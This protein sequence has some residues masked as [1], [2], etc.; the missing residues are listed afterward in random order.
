[1]GGWYRQGVDVNQEVMAVSE[2]IKAGK[3]RVEQR[4]K[5]QAKASKKNPK[6]LDPRTITEAD[7][8]EML[9][10]AIYG[11]YDDG[12][13]LPLRRNTPEFFIGVVKEHSKGTYFIEDYPIAA[14]VE[15]LR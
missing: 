11:V 5:K 13:Y 10:N 4:Y 3:E 1:M 12:K 15:H 7:V 6:K 8:V 2:D 14:K 9:E